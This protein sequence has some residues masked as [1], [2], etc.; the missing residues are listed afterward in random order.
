MV[1]VNQ[2]MCYVRTPFIGYRVLPMYAHLLP[3]CEGRPVEYSMS[4]L[5]L[6]DGVEGYDEARQQLFSFEDAEKRY[7]GA[8]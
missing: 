7:P 1:L 6:F 4:A 5:Y 3:K 8:H 2:Y